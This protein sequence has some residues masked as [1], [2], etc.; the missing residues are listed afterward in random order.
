MRK[1][2]RDVPIIFLT[3]A[4]KSEEF[5]QRGF[6]VGAVDYLLKPI[7]DNLLINK[8]S[9]YFRLIEKE[10]SLNRSLEQKVAKRT[11]ELEQARQYLA[12]ILS[13]MGEA[14]LVLNPEGVI[15][16]ANPAA[17]RMLGYMEA[18][19]IGLSMGMSSRRKLT[20]R[21]APLW[22]PGSKRP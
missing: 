17:C 12:N 9:T 8:I 1:R 20:R 18:E 3:A 6:A 14:L 7:D 22:V 10:R 21:P 16:T 4:F 5:Q 19:L 13:H 11:A 15:K 2:T